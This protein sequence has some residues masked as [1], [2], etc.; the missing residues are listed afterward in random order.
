MSLTPLESPSALTKQWLD[1][2]LIQ[3]QNAFDLGEVPVGAIIIL[4]NAIVGRGFNQKEKGIDVTSHAEIMAI[5]DAASHVGD[6][7]LDSATLVSTLEPCPMCAG[8]I[9]HSRI[10]HV[11]YGAADYKWGANGTKIDL[12]KPGLF[13]H[14]TSISWIN[15]PPCGD[16]LTR[17]FKSLRDV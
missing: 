6:W 13:N 11:I 16:I 5:R 2:A 8:A 9:L 14:T 15:Y 3:A 17:F 1:L 10:G 4:E 12:F 7:R